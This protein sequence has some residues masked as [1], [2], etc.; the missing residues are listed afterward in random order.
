MTINNTSNNKPQGGVL[1]KIPLVFWFL[2][3]GLAA[4]SACD[5]EEPSNPTI[6]AKQPP[7]PIIDSGVWADAIHSPTIFWLDNH[8]IIFKGT[9]AKQKA[10]FFE[11]TE[12]QIWDVEKNKIAPYASTTKGIAC[13]RDGTIFYWIKGNKIGEDRYRYGKIG[14]E[15]TIELQK[16]KKTV[17]DTMNCRVLDADT[18]MKDRKIRFL[19][20]HH[21]YLDIGPLKEWGLSMAPITLYRPGVSKGTTVSIPARETYIIQHYPFQGAYLV[22]GLN[23]GGIPGKKKKFWWLYPEGKVKEDSFHIET[24][25]YPTRKGIVTKWG[26]TKSAK[27]PG[28]VGLYLWNGKKPIKLIS[29]YAEGIT[30]SPDG[31]KLTFVHFLYSDATLL[32]D[33]GRITLKAINVCLEEKTHGQ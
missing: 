25:L 13:Y 9:E 12:L 15:K 6:S 26:G 27:D 21:G 2:V 16:D 8:R 17:I 20:E 32:K 14:Y 29:G 3:A 28:T 10:E 4:I 11:K 1:K 24:D 19:L 18:T 7:Y 5:A 22:Y 33:P 30:V 23:T 31:C